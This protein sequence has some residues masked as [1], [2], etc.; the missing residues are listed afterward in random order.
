MSVMA[1]RPKGKSALPATKDKNFI[2][3]TEKIFA[4]L[5]SF[6]SNPHEPLSLDQITSSVGF[7]KTSAHRLL[8]SMRRL[9]YIQ[10]DS[11]GNYSLSEKFYA[12]GGNALP[13]QH[14]ISLSRPVLN[15]LVMRYGESVH[16][17]VL[18][19][20]VVLFVAV[21]P[22][23][24]AYR[25]AAEVG[26]C[27]YAHSTAL[28][29]CLLANLPVADRDAVLQ[30]R[31]LPKMTER[32][33]TSRPQL[34]LDLERIRKQGWA[35]NDGENIEGVICVAAPIFG[36]GDQV[37]AALSMSG[38]SSRMQPVLEELKKAVRNAASRLSL[39]LGARSSGADELVNAG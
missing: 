30:A 17:G 36:R 7:A 4:V 34:E 14:L 2:A 19:K 20:G 23:Q 29:K 9:G 21:A 13:Y 24:H 27:N 5:E 3:V 28:G 16:I 32:T 10:Q 33:K 39:L 22:S 26:E 15:Q 8:Y 12:L 38:P 18:E 35:V 25:C 37:I 1:R 6:N 31:G 11:N